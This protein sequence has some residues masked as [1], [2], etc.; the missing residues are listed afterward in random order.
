M[1]SILVLETFN[2]AYCF[3]HIFL[4]IIKIIKQYTDCAIYEL[5]LKTAECEIFVSIRDLVFLIA[6]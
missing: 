4:K 3:T 6:I 1:S 5:N 2:T